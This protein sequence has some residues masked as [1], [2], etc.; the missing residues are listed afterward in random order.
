M[1]F[2]K[3]KATNDWQ[4]FNSPQYPIAFPPSTRCI[5]RVEAPPG[6]KVRLEFIDFLLLEKSQT[7]TPPNAHCENQSLTILNINSR[8]T[9]PVVVMC[10]EL[11]PRPMISR[12]WGFNIELNSNNVPYDYN[13][14]GFQIKYKIEEDKSSLFNSFSQLKNKQIMTTGMKSLPKPTNSKQVSSR[15][16]KSGKSKTPSKVQVRNWTQILRTTLPKMQASRASIAPTE[17]PRYR[18][19]DKYCQ[20]GYPCPKNGYFPEISELNQKNMKKKAKY[21]A[22]KTVSITFVILF[23]IGCLAIIGHKKYLEKQEQ[24]N[25]LKKENNSRNSNYHRK[26]ELPTSR[27]GSGFTDDSYSSHGLF[28]H[29]DPHTG[30]RSVY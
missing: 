8:D 15:G 18:P 9:D 21:S 17:K 3:Y 25:K 26:L 23:L 5:F 19:E 1:C 27:F 16:P 30:L 28:G 11:K 10:G 4:T 20:P 29:I 6:Y 22:M 12:T 14:R 7:T 13:Y 2:T 24:Q